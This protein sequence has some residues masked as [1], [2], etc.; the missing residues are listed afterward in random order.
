M[1]VAM[2]IIGLVGFAMDKLLAL[3]EARLQSWRI[4]A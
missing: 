2:V 3:A 1:I 4:D